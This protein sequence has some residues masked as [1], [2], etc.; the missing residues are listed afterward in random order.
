MLYDEILKDENFININ[1]KSKG[2]SNPFEF[3]YPGCS[4]C[5]FDEKQNICSICLF[6]LSSKKARPKCCNHIFCYNC[7]V[8]WSRKKKV[9]PICRKKYLKLII[10]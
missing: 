3:Y 8:L 5:V 2:F 6:P 1:I 4:K 7:I 9:C 10:L